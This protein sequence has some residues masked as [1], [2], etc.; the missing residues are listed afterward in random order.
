MMISIKSCIFDC[1]ETSALLERL[2]ICTLGGAMRDSFMHTK[3]IRMQRLNRAT[4]LVAE[5]QCAFVGPL[6]SAFDAAIKTESF[7]LGVDDL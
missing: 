5:V 7:A 6:R 4:C 2:A 1:Y 3:C